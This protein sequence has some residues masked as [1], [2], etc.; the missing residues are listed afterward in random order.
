[1]NGL[2]RTSAGDV[3]GLRRDSVWE[4]LGIPFAAPPSGPRR[5]RRPEPAVSW[6]G[7]READRFGP[8]A[9]QAPP[10]PGM[11]ILG[12][13]AESSE[14]CLTL[15]VWT[16]GTDDAGR[17]VLVWIH[18][19][20]FTSGSGAS[21]LYRGDRLAAM[22]DVVVVTI[23]YRL[24]ALGFMAHPAL[25]ADGVDGW[26]NWGLLDQISALSWVRE[27]ITNFGGDPGNVTVF[28]ESAGAMSISVLLG[29]PDA[30]GLFSRAVV[31]SGPPASGSAQ[32]GT[33]RAEAFVEGFGSDGPDS[34]GS[35]GAFDRFSLEQLTADQLVHA[36]QQLRPEAGSLPLPFLPVVDGAVLPL[37]PA[38]AVRDGCGHRVPILIGTNRDECTFFAL[39]DQR[40]HGL[41]EDSLRRRLTVLLGSEFAEPVIDCYRHARSAR[42][43]ATDPLALWTSITTDL[44]FRAPSLAFAEAHLGAGNAVYSYLFTWS[45]PFLGGILGAAH[46]LEIP[47]VFGTVGEKRVQPYSGQ[48]PAA[49]T[50][51]T[52]MMSSWISF[53]R[54]GD[55]SSDEVGEWPPYETEKR[56]TMI[57]GEETALELD[58]RSPER[59]VFAAIGVDMANRLHHT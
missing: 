40:V 28:G 33:R 20:G 14:D 3:R 43:E 59:E 15:N 5:W 56:A 8:I 54:S 39:A 17:P 38:K 26:G 37:P 52:A 32:W 48:G 2:T 9:P 42:D 31:Q 25:A 41:N 44:V 12:D 6:R 1:M 47:F 24:G 4:F 23:N 35:S 53:A 36:T 45:S 16:P 58:P 29:S 46:A 10:V 7:V 49:D 21:L 11:S 22:G 34:E 51:A 50:L 18:G 30:S 19:G 27:N 57:F 55:P 13:P